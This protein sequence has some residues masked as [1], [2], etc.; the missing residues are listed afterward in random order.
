MHLAGLDLGHRRIAYVGMLNDASL[1]LA[2]PRARF[3]LVFGRIGLIPDMGA[4]AL[5]TTFSH[6]SF[7]LRRN[8]IP[9]FHYS[10]F[11]SLRTRSNK[12]EPTLRIA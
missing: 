3:C 12:V 11:A 2:T 9:L 7:W 6:R 8:Q 10:F 1:S 4:A 5:L